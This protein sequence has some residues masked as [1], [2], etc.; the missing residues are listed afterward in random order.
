[1]KPLYSSLYSV[2]FFLSGI[3]SLHA[4]STDTEKPNIVVILVDDMGY[5]DLGCYGSEIQTPNLD[6]LAQNGIRY[7][8]MYNTSKCTTTR[9]ALLMGRYVDR[10]SWKANYNNGP[11]LGEFARQ[12]GYRTLW[13]GKNH[14]SILPTERGFDRFYGFQGGCTNFWNPGKKTATGEAIPHIETHP[15][16]INDKWVKVFEPEDPNYYATDAF[17][18]NA[19]AWLREYKN[20]K[21][22][23]FLYLAY[24]SPHWPL[25][26]HQKDINKYKGKYDKGY[27]ALQQERYERML[28]NQWIDPKTTT[29][30]TKA[31]K[32][33]SSLSPEQ[34]KDEAE[35]MEVHAAMVDNLDQNIGKVI[36]QLKANG[37][38]DNTLIL[39]LS[40][41]GASSESLRKSDKNYTQT[42]AEVIGSVFSY[43]SIGPQWAQVIN[44]PYAKYKKTSHE[45]GICTPMIAHWPKG[46]SDP[47]SWSDQP[48]H[49]VDIYS[50]LLDLTN[51]NYPATWEQQST[52]SPQ[53]ISLT[54][55]FSGN[56]LAE[57]EHLMGF[58][59]ATGRAIREKNWKLVRFGK[60]HWELY[61]L[62]IDRNE[63]NDL[64]KQMP[65]KVREMTS[66]FEQWQERC[67]F[68][69]EEHPH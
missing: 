5:S 11:N 42:G 17:T 61:N 40:D 25:H 53:G 55:T 22:P 34:Q 14:S 33:W 23:F 60:K 52:R 46:I 50:T 57:R 24:T 29:L 45:G 12:A 44:T 21:K 19:I 28:K 4:Q 35:R 41:N 1:M 26:A 9:S 43:K 59:F 7:S 54:P 51:F 20:D 16:M 65:E 30:H 37:V 15:W 27:Q 48:A 2:L 64:A 63:A 32:K 69:D 8:Q 66:L 18:D 62:E 36:A 58:D 10:N 68:K 31:I 6:L 49:L 47:N 13:S 39:F 38:F 67:Q 56:S 3:L